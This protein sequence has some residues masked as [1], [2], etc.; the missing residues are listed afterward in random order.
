MPNPYKINEGDKIA[1]ATITAA[2]V[3][4]SP[5]R[6]PANAEADERSALA[7]YKRILDG[8]RLIHIEAHE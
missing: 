1:A 5:T 4:K 7:L 8:V 2:L 6:S 3:N